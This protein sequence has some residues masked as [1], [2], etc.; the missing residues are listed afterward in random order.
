MKPTRIITGQTG[1]T[2]RPDR[3]GRSASNLPVLAVNKGELY[4]Y[5]L[6]GHLVSLLATLKAFL[7]HLSWS[8]PLSHTLF[9]G[10]AFLWVWELPSAMHQEFELCVTRETSNKCHRL[11]SFGSCRSLDGLEELISW[12]PPRILL[13]SPEIDCERSCAHLTGVVKI[14]SSGIE[15]WRGSL[16]QV[17]LRSR[18]FLI[19]EWL[20]FWIH[21]NLD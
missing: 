9:L 1:L 7:T 4:I 15:V 17:G 3:S 20:T 10:M 18:G 21:L 16:I 11:V 5:P 12:S 2:G 8:S 19:E 6:A 14:N 13:R